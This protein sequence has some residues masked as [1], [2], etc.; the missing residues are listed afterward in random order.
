MPWY[1]QG[2]VAVTNGSVTVTGTGTLFSTNS[3]VGDAFQGPD[4]RWYEVTNIASSTVLSILPAYQ[5]TTDSSGAYGLAPM[6]GYVKESADQLRQIVNQYGTTLAL[7]GNATSNSQ[8]LTNIGA[9]NRGANSDIT[10]LTG[11]TTALSVAQGG[12]GGTTQA[13][14][15]TGLGLGDAATK[16][17]ATSKTDTT[18]SR[19]PFIGYGGIGAVGSNPAPAIGNLDG[20]SF[21]GLFYY[22]APTNQGPAGA[23]GTA[24]VSSHQDGSF[25]CLTMSITNSK[26]AYRSYNAAS[27]FSTWGEFWTTANTTVDG[28]GFVKRASP[29]VRISDTVNSTRGDLLENFSK[30][31]DWGVFNEEARGVSVVR[32]SKGIYVISGSDGLAQEGW[33]VGSPTDRNGGAKLGIATGKNEEGLV[34]IEL[35]KIRYTLADDGSLEQVQGD[36]MDVPVDAWIDVRLDMPS[37]TNQTSET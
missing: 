21:G 31:S 35:R 12:T 32:K 7:F 24:L 22:S 13:A 2:T 9:A 37:K 14:A 17:V 29:I 15:R 11:L 19:L 26:I 4:G 18:A 6:Q 27:G 20:L 5:G 3:R 30:V 33:Q 28:S 10:S 34:V 36:L 8:L 16:T 23:F 1:R 25:G